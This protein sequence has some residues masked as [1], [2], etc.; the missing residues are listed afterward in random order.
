MGPIDPFG[1]SINK[2]NNPNYD[3]KLSVSQTRLI[4]TV[5]FHKALAHYTRKPLRN[6]RA[7]QQ[8]K[9][10]QHPQLPTSPL[11]L[12][13]RPLRRR[14]QAQREVRLQLLRPHLRVRVNRRLGLEARRRPLPRERRPTQTQT[15]HQLRLHL[16]QPEAHQ[17]LA[18]LQLIQEHHHQPVQ[19][20][21]GRAAP[22]HRPR[23]RPRDTQR[24]HSLLH[25]EEVP[26]QEP[27]PQRRPVPGHLQPRQARLGHHRERL[28]HPHGLHRQ[29][30]VCFLSCEERPAH[31]SPGSHRK[32]AQVAE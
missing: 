22:A 9:S 12:L 16:R 4:P 26:G 1:P 31:R 17:A 3:L 30:G 27:P 14:L 15:R 32:P 10:S 19:P 24:R 23:Q 28:A 13:Q 25:K 6:H 2:D 8:T 18:L 11:L 5:Q 21:H 20:Q 7:R 29:P